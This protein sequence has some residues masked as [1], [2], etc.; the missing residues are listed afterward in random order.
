ML[1][2]DV[3][4]WMSMDKEKVFLKDT[5]QIFRNANHFG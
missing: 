5:C 3:L 1:L 4:K 2:L